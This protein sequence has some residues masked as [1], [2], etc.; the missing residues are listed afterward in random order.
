MTTTDYS[1]KDYSRQELID[2]ASLTSEDLEQINQCRRNYNRL[3]FAYQIGFVRLLN[4][5]P[6]PNPFEIIDELLTFTSVQLQI[7][8]SAINQYAQRQQTISQH[9][10]QILD[11]LKLKRFSDEQRQLLRSFVFEEACR[12][13]QTSALF[14]RAEQFLREQKILLY[15]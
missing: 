4:Q 5:F 14:L 1:R 15:C 9:Q 8:E 2:K 6:T 11:Y 10:I 13:E 12:L 3:G 7:S